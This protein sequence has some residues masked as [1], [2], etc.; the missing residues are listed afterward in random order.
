MSLRPPPSNTKADFAG[1]E[2]RNREILGLSAR[3]WVRVWVSAAVLATTALIAQSAY[4]VPAPGARGPGQNTTGSFDQQYYQDACEATVSG[5]TLTITRPL[6]DWGGPITPVDDF[7]P[8]DEQE[9][10]AQPWDV[11]DGFGQ[12]LGY[13]VTGQTSFRGI[14]VTTAH[15]LSAGTWRDGALVT[16]EETTIAINGAPTPQLN[17]FA[18]AVERMIVI[19]L[20]LAACQVQAVNSAL[21]MT[22]SAGQETLGDPGTYVMGFSPAAVAALDAGLGDESSD[23]A[24]G[25]MDDWFT[26]RAAALGA[27]VN[28]RTRLQHDLRR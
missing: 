17:V 1:G 15:T 24:Q 28:I 5:P 16:E 26:A 4:A 11:S 10:P 23:D 19:R 12:G 27:F 25:M 7:A 6:P 18:V 2:R 21:A 3:A 22:M 8:I 13:G 20:N 14:A 9:A